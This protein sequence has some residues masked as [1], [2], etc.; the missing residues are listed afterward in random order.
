MPYLRNRLAWAT[1][2]EVDLFG[3]HLDAYINLLPTVAVLRLCH[4]HG[5]ASAISKIPVE[6]LVLIEDFLTESERDKTREIWQAEYKCFQDK[7]EPMDHYDRSRVND[8]RR[9][10]RLDTARSEALAA[11]DVDERVNEFIIDHTGYFDV[12]MER[13]ECWV[14]R[15]ESVG[16]VSKNQQRKRREIMM[17]H[18][19]L[20]FW[21]SRTRVAGESDN[22]GYSAAEAT[23]VRD[24]G[25]E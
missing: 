21:F 14:E 24:A 19:G 22:H 12:H 5:K 2:V 25:V 17:K 20:D 23:L 3:A 18:F 16:V 6:L 13:G 10:I 7:C 1:P 11:E 15:S 4:R 9:M 8:W